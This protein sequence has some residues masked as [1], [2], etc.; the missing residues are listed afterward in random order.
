MSSNRLSLCRIRYNGNYTRTGL[1]SHWSANG[2]FNFVMD[3]GFSAS[4][5]R[6]PGVTFSEQSF[7]SRG[8]ESKP[9]ELLVKGF[10]KISGGMID[11]GLVASL[12]VL[13]RGGNGGGLFL[14]MRSSNPSLYVNFSF[15]LFDG[16]LFSTGPAD[17]PYAAPKS[18]STRESTR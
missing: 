5:P 2:A 8:P 18:S 4:R 10:L 12:V 6:P 17:S 11:D 15:P 3:Q 9:R 1:S 7:S 14:A 16:F 13:T